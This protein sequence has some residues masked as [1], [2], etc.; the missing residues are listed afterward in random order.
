MDEK[1]RLDAP[2]NDSLSGIEQ[3]GD[4]S[5]LSTIYPHAGKQWEG[6]LVSQEERER[7]RQEKEDGMTL[8]IRKQSWKVG[9]LAPLPFVLL[10]FFVAGS[11]IGIAHSNIDLMVIP[12]IIAFIAWVGISFSIFRRIFALFYAHALRAVPFLLLL[13]V[14][15]GLS[16]QTVYILTIPIHSQQ[17]LSAVALVSVFALLW[18]MFMSYILLMIWT[19]PAMNG[20]VKASVIATMTFGLALIASLVTFLA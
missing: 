1:H 5:G 3:V 14:L 15:L 11:V 4:R 2:N 17:L 7:R 13:F 19:T 12:M 16:I 10:S 9:L 8:G 20:A 18:G 6:D